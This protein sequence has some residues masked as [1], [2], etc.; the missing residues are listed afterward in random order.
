M[1]EC[2]G[3]GQALPSPRQKA[4]DSARGPSLGLLGMGGATDFGISEEEGCGGGRA[5]CIA[6]R[7]MGCFSIFTRDPLGEA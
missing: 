1:C 3:K 7:E 5:A 6:V 4:R 2:T